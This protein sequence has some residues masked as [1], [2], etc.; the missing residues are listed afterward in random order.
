MTA[1]ATPHTHRRTFSTPVGAIAYEKVATALGSY[2]RSPATSP[3]LVAALKARSGWRQKAA[4]AGGDPEGSFEQAFGSLAYNYLK[5]NAPQ[6]LDHVVGFQLVDRDEDKTKACGLFGIKLGDQ[7]LYAPVFFLNGELKGHELLYVKAKDAFVPLKENWV[8]YLQ[9]RRPQQLGEQ[10]QQDA[11]QL[12][13]MAPDISRLAYLPGMGKMSCD[14]WAVPALP[15]MAAAL[16]QPERLLTKHADVFDR[17]DLRRFL[18]TSPQA[19]YA[20]H[21]AAETYP[22]VKQALDRFYGP[23]LLSKAAAFHLDRAKRQINSLLPVQRSPLPAGPRHL[24][25]TPAEK[26]AVEIVEQQKKLKVYDDASKTVNDPELT[27]DDRRK[28]LLDGVLIKDERDPHGVSV[29]YDTQVRQALANPPE[30]GLYDVLERP[31]KFDRML[32][33]KSPHSQRGRES[34]A[35]VVRL[36]DGAKSWLNAHATH[37]WARDEERFDEYRAWWDKLPEG[38]SCEIGATYMAVS[39]R[40]DATVPFTVREDYSD[41]AYRVDFDDHCRHDYRR[42]ASRSGAVPPEP[43]LDNTEYFSAYGAT[44]RVNQRDGSKLRSIRGELYVPKSFRLLKLK[45]PAKLSPE[46]QLGPGEPADSAAEPAPIE[47][48]SIEDVQLLFLEKT[49]ALRVVNDGPT[50]TVEGSGVVKAGAYRTALVHL[51]RERGLTEKVAQEVLAQARAARPRGGAARFRIKYADGYDDHYGMLQGGPTTPAF[52]APYTGTEFNGPNAVNS[53][54]P[55]EEFLPVTP[56]DANRTDPRIYDPWMNYKFDQNSMATAGQAGAS[57]QK[58]VFD[59][60]MI[61][62]LLKSVSQDSLVD[63]YLPDLTRAL[64]RLGRILFG[65]FWH[66]DLFAER[67]GSQDL[68]ELEDSLRNAFDS[69]GDLVLYLKEKT[70]DFDLDQPGEPDLGDAAQ[71]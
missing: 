32:I 16:R 55:Q 49:A 59:T 7:W 3:Q 4:D 47:P 37:L 8:N 70:I 45:G 6:L 54:Y 52:S 26:R 65:F 61:S 35:T 48:G 29:V 69:T 50:Y 12:G 17:L 58:E 9:G 27:E 71:A 18:A 53:I 38:F 10:S 57:G 34:F 64:D 1:L 33:V 5:S 31:G 56:L 15:L 43:A 22:A 39:E 60:S 68:P 19:A 42:P 2:W 20:L 28:A 46:E 67:Y 30:T 21:A 25:P 23:D 62:G 51:V 66:Q 11:Y 40:G 24:I 36:G 13:G 14:R 63:R 41:G 44:L